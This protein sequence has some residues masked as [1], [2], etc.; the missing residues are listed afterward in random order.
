MNLEAL[1]W[2]DGVI[3]ASVVLLAQILA[4]IQIMRTKEE[5]RSAVSWLGLVW[6]API[7]GLLVYMLFGINRIQR[8]ARLSRE[9]RGLLPRS[10]ILTDPGGPMT[11]YREE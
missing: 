3:I 6:L 5:V 7:F 11:D 4:S 8:R 1:I 9:K 2:P 10:D